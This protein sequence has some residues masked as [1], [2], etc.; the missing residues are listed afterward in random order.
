MRVALS[1]ILTILF[2]LH[3]SVRAADDDEAKAKLEA[4]KKGALDRWSGLEVGESAPL[5]ET[6]RFLVIAPKSYENRM[7]SIGSLLESAFDKACAALKIDAVMDPPWPGKLA[8]YILP[9][10]E[11]FTSFIRRVEQRRLEVGELGSYRIDRDHPHAVGGPPT[12]TDP[13][14][15]VQAIQQVAAALLQKKAGART[16]LPGWLIEGFGR[17][18]YYRVAPN[19]TVVKAERKKTVDLVIRGKKSTYDLLNDRLPPEEVALIG[20]SLAD[21]LAYSAGASKF[22]AMVE[23]FK[24]E[25]NME[26][27]NF[28]MVLTDLKIKA[29]QLEKSW[30]GWVPRAQ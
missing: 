26:S 9:E 6:P 11:Q 19:D 23:G 2:V 25:E 13:T 20:P 30:R 14:P 7:K 8:V 24:L 15:D 3:L 29:D 28:G 17:A 4:Q 1:A 21:F 18:T 22:P 5:L 27:R 16:P 12:G 10:R